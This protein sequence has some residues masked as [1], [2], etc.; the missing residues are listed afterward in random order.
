MGRAEATKQSGWGTDRRAA[1]P[2]CRAL[3]RRARNDICTEL[4]R[5]DTRFPSM[6]APGP[7]DRSEVG[8]L[9]GI[10][11]LDFS[12][13]MAGGLATLVLSDFGAEVIKIEPPGGDPFRKHP[14]WLTWNRGKKGIV[15][16]LNIGGHRE[17]ARSLAGSADILLEAFRPGVAARLGI[18]YQ[19]LVDLNPGLVYCSISGFGQSGPLAGIKGYEGVVAAR[20]GRMMTFEEQAPRRGPVYAAVPVASWAASQA[21]VHGIL[22]ALMVRDRSGQG[23]W[24]QT[25]LLQAITAYDIQGLTVRQFMQWHPERYK[26]DPIVTIRRVPT[27]QYL[28]ARCKDG[29]WLQLANNNFRLFQSTIRAMGLW[30]I[31]QIGRAHV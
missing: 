30:Y 7:N 20:A 12:W 25:S 18:G 19:D 29:R 28:P 14:A 13:G 6:S 5:Q 15:L 23:Q 22:A 3:L 27:L 10:R 17:R 4:L 8:P 31:Y 21:A 16:D 9:E 26:E 2:D 24:V 11:V 1:P